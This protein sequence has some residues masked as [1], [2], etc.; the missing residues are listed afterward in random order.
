[1]TKEEFLALKVG[2]FVSY[3]C[4]TYAITKTTPHRFYADAVD[5][6]ASLTRVVGGM[7]RIT[8]CDRNGMPI[9]PAPTDAEKHAAWVA[10]LKPGDEVEWK[11]I[12]ADGWY[13]G[14]VVGQH[15]GYVAVLCDGVTPTLP[16]ANIRPIQSPQPAREVGCDY[17]A[18]SGG[19]SFP[20]RGWEDTLTHAPADTAKVRGRL[21]HIDKSDHV[22]IDGVRHLSLAAISAADA[23]TI[24]SL[25][26][27]IARRDAIIAELTAKLAAMQPKSE[28]T[29]DDKRPGW[30]S[31]SLLTVR[32]MGRVGG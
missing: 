25:R 28:P 29:Q 9:R 17:S 2:D 32:G 24:D 20:R 26:A 5:R 4:V 7:E 21:I 8:R 13:R 31:R 16:E 11:P 18:P 3:E 23:K 30:D 1:M 14:S 19:Q 22:F 27:D 15:M 12:L 6:R 10:S